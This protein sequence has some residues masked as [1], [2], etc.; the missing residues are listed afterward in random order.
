MTQTHTHEHGAGNHDAHV[1]EHTAEARPPTQPSHAVVLDVGEHAGALILTCS[2]QREGL[3]VEIHPAS[4]PDRRTH[5]WVLPRLG[6]AGLTV[7]AAV[8]PRLAPGA[9]M[10]LEPDGTPGCTVAIPAN[11]VTHA[12]W[13]A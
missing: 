6:R 3:E 11:H 10:V 5:V 4:E 12:A 9:Y 2:P 8:F 13:G 1:H 7:Y